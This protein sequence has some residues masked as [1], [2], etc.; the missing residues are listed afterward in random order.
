MRQLNSRLLLSAVAA[1]VF[2]AGCGGGGDG[3]DVVAAD[4]PAP[5]GPSTLQSIDFIKNMIASESENSDP[6]DLDAIT[7]AVDDTA[8][9]VAL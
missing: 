7:L 9:P 2:V 5:S 8:D 4:P 3:A 1:A 6:H